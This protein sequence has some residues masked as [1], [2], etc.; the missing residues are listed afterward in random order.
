MFRPMLFD[1]LET[2]LTYTLTATKLDSAS[3]TPISSICECEYLRKG[4]SKFLAHCWVRHSYI[5][6]NAHSVYGQKAPCPHMGMIQ[7][8]IGTRYSRMADKLQRNT[9]HWNQTAGV[10]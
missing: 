5:Y 9:G 4:V 8:P 2:L 10:R 3:A 1:L 7:S 6:D